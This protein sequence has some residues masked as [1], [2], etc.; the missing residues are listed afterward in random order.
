M[1]HAFIFDFVVT[2]VSL[3]L[4]C[5]SPVHAQK[6]ETIE[7]VRVV[8]NGG[9]GAWGDNPAVTLHFD[10]HLGELDTDD[11]NFMFY[12]PSDVA[13]DTDGN[14][15]VLDAGYH[16]IQKF[17]RNHAYLAS[18]GEEG[19][20]PGEFRQP[21]SIDVDADG[22]MYVG[23]QG[24]NRMQIMTPTGANKGTFL[25]D[26][27]FN[28]FRLMPGGELLMSSGGMFMMRMRMIENPKPSPLLEVYTQDGMLLR[29]IGKPLDYNNLMLNRVG[30][31]IFYTVGQ[32]GSVYITF[33]HQNRIEKYAPEGELLLSI[34]RELNYD[35]I[36]PDRKK[37]HI[38]ASEGNVRVT[39]PQMTEVSAAIDVDDKGRI[40]VVTADRQIREDEQVNRM[41]SVEESGGRRRM[42]LSLSGATDLY[43]TD[44]Y[45]IEIFAPDG[46]LLGVIPLDHFCD[47]MRI[48]DG[49]LYINDKLRSMRYYVYTIVEK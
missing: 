7:G 1:R 17:D 10:G 32:D 28:L 19:Q 45:K 27:G 38:E 18:F 5:G 11:E 23:D 22:N 3:A 9:P 25:L 44:M 34:D 36:E 16:R 43:D 26:K 42:S 29:E 33:H 2:A 13:A 20:G 4:L 49:R 37:Q 46:I 40:W 30:N 24:N 21:V 47:G 8:H 14:V 15:Y 39:M 41:I 12:L 35:V 31:E 6:V 48:L